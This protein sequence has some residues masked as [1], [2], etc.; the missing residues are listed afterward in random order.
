MRLLDWVRLILPACP[1]A[2]LVHLDFAN[3]VAPEDL[4]LPPSCFHN[5][6]LNPVNSLLS[7][8]VQSSLWNC[9][10]HFARV[11]GVT[12]RRDVPPYAINRRTGIVDV[13]ETVVEPLLKIKA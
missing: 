4:K 1:R 7:P 2:L 13:V 6:L 10:K 9:F 5:Q 12:Q 11:G 3:A 8:L